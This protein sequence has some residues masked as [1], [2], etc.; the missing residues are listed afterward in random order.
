MLVACTGIAKTSARGV[1]NYEWRETNAK[2]VITKVVI[3]P[4]SKCNLDNIDDVCNSVYMRIVNEGGSP[5]LSPDIHYL[6]AMNT[7]VPGY[8]PEKSD[9]EMMFSQLLTTGRFLKLKGVGA[10][11][12]SAPRIVIEPGA[13]Y[14]EELSS[15]GSFNINLIRSGADRVNI[16][17]VITYADSDIPPGY[18][19]ISEFCG[20]M[21]ADKSTMEHCPYRNKTWLG[22]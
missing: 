2:L 3:G 8:V 15:A 5:A 16:S 9:I 7:N 1:Q 17:S 12:K 18:Y 6:V 20:R 10:R 19:W 13:H 22:H 4:S 14:D 11:R 21:S